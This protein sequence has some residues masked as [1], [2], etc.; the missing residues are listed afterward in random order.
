MKQKTIQQSPSDTNAFKI[1]FYANKQK[2][3][4]EHKNVKIIQMSKDF[5]ENTLNLLLA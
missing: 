5:A 1:K 3:I 2:K 4:K